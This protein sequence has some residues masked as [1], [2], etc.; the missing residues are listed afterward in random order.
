VRARVADVD[1][2]VAVS[3][4]YARNMQDYLGIPADKMTGARRGVNATGARAQ[5]T[6]GL[7]LV[8][9]VL[10]QMRYANWSLSSALSPDL[11]RAIRDGDDQALDEYSTPERAAMMA[12]AENFGR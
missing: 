9:R 4:N 5:E 2:F 1:L 11:L 12:L 8:L 10:T 3:E 6:F 7:L